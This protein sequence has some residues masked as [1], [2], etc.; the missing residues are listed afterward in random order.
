[1]REDMQEELTV[2]QQPVVD[3]IE[4]HAI[5]AHV[6]EHL[7]RDD[8]IEAPLRREIVHVAGDYLDVAQTALFGPRFDVLPLRIR[9]GYG[10]DAGIWEV[11][12]D[13][14]RH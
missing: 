3:A 11:L 1:M 5:V 12:G 7:D 13:K 8:A 9:V 4:E 2:R 6:L 10:Q 14:Q